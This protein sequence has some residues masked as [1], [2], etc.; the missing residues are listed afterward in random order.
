MTVCERDVLLSREGT[1]VNKASVSF[2]HIR[3]PTAILIDLEMPKV[4]RKKSNAR[5][6]NKETVILKQKYSIGESESDLPV[7][8]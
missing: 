8:K 6:R 1:T 4:T 5:Q 7:L 3:P 2:A